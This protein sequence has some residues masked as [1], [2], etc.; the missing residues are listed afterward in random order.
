MIVWSFGKC[1]HG[2][3]LQ[4]WRI[5]KKLTEC[6]C[7]CNISYGMHMKEKIRLTELLLGMDHGCIT[8]NPNQ[9]LQCNGNIPVH[10]Q[11]NSSMFKVTPSA[12]KVMLTVFWDSQGVLL[13]HFQKRGENVNSATYCKVLLKLRDTIR[14]KY[15][16]QLTRGALLHHDN[17]RQDTARVT[18]ERIRELQW[19]LFEHPPY[20]PDL[21]PSHFH[22]LSQLKET[23]LVANHPL[24]TKRLK[25][26]CGSGWDNSQKTSMLQ[27]ST[28][29]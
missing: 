25:R 9:R 17:T 12:G 26:R 16:G 15:P 28:D 14:R 5:E 21:A 4:N 13:A 11:P 24:M 19:K 2:R 3:C 6:V 29:W 27:V 23:I 1:T 10:I 18:Q 20:S 22:L 7:P 8:T